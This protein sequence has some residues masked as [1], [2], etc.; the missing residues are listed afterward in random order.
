MISKA[1]WLL[2]EYLKEKGYVTENPANTTEMEYFNE[3]FQ[4]G[5][6]PDREFG[7]FEYF[8]SNYYCEW[9]LWVER[10]LVE[11]NSL[12]SEQVINMLITCIASLGESQ[13]PEQKDSD[14]LLDWEVVDDEEDSG[15]DQKVS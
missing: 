5:Y 14:V 13:E 12:T 4:F 2:G 6:S 15:G 8:P 10:G 3:V 7:Y 11:S 1:L 9:Y